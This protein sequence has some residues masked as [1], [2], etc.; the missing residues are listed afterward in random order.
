[1]ELVRERLFPGLYLEPSTNGEGVH[2]Y[3]ILEKLGIK[4]DLV[5]QVLK[6]LD[7]YLKK[8]AASVGAD[9]ACV[10]V[11]GLPPSIEYDDNGNITAHHLR[12]VGQAATRPRRAGHLQGQVRRPGPARS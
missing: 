12:P 9:I 11:K 8:L 2:G 1:M 6:N 7:A 5:R 10:E 3:F 4:T